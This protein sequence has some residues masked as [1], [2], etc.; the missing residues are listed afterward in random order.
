VDKAF[1]LIK[2][3]LIFGVDRKHAGFKSAHL[4]LGKVRSANKKAG[5]L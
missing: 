1:C 4:V 2:K 5:S 3:R